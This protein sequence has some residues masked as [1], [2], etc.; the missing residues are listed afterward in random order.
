VV[1][2][3]RTVAVRYVDTPPRRS[4]IGDIEASNGIVYDSQRRRRLGRAEL[5]GVVT[6]RRP[7][8]VQ[9]S[10]TLILERGRISALGAAPFESPRPAHLA[11]VGGTDAYR[12]ARGEATLGGGPGGTGKVT[13]RLC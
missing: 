5:S 2:V 4:V 6:S 11:V 12:G 7:F 3:V 10:V 13:V 8:I 1:F 9:L